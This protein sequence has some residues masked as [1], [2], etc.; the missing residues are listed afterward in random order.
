MIYVWLFPVAACLGWWAARVVRA[1]A[2][3]RKQARDA[4]AQLAAQ[5]RARRAAIQAWSDELACAGNPPAHIASLRRAAAEPV[6][7]DVRSC[8][9]AEGDLAAAMRALNCPPPAE[10][11][12]LTNRVRIAAEFYNTQAL[13]YNTRLATMSLKLVARLAGHRP[14]DAFNVM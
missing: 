14:L 1:L 6:P 4:W 8:C 5:L 9:Q 10:V 7:A 13:V 11:G 3:L 12:G 2:R